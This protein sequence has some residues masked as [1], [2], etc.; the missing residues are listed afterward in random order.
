MMEQVYPF[1]ELLQKVEQ[2]DKSLQKVF[3]LG[4]YAS[5]YVIG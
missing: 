5:G 3:V 1:G 2:L 4:G